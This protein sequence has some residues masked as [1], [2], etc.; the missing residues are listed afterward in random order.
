[1]MWYTNTKKA[2]TGREKVG[3]ISII[4]Y[5]AS[6]KMARG[7]D[8][9]TKYSNFCQLLI[10]EV[11]CFFRILAPLSKPAPSI[12]SSSLPLA[13]PPFGGDGPSCTCCASIPVF[14]VR[15]RQG[16]VPRCLSGCRWWADGVDRTI[17]FSLQLPPNPLRTS[18]SGML[19]S[20]ISYQKGA[21]LLKIS[22]R[23]SHN[24]KWVYPGLAY[25]DQGQAWPVAGSVG[26][27]AKC[28][29]SIF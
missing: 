3:N 16:T 26:S 12:P 21:S 17:L 5:G 19:A 18:L 23:S 20:P 24:L 27:W 6:R 1:M 2:T 10:S 22:G 25:S 9:L 29:E 4:Y 14:C 13:A 7:M 15:S 8:W 11:L 28:K